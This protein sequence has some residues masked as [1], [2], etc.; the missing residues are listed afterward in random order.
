MANTACKQ[1]GQCCLVDMSVFVTAED[2]QRW[3]QEGRQ[4]ILEMIEKEGTIWAGGTTVSPQS[5]KE[6]WACPFLT[7]RDDRFACS[8]Y[9]TRPVVCEHFAP[10]S[11]ELCSQFGRRNG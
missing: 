2:E 10:G 4:D 1:C 5:G 8:I 9:E 6:M 11:S 7:P 3:E